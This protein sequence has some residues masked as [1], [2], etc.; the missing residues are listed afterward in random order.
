MSGQQHN[1][2]TIVST[3][4][5]AMDAHI[6]KGRLEAE[7]IPAYLTDDQYI[8]MDWTVSVAIGGVKVH[9][10]DQYLAAALD[11][12]ENNQSGA[13]DLSSSSSLDLSDELAKESLEEPKIYCPECNSTQVTPFN[14]F[15]KLSLLMLFIY[16]TP[17][18]FSKQYYQC[19][20]CPHIFRVTNSN[21]PLFFWVVMAI[22]SIIL[23]VIVVFTLVAAGG[24]ST[25]HYAEGEPTTLLLEEDSD[26]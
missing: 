21:S 23:A 2:N 10:P 13:Y 1:A 24:V 6:I 16:H 15:W 11:V 12:L 14:W 25:H 4:T 7:G 26:P 18:A 17:L 8:T 22:A 19:E 9:V 5:I 3:H 20:K